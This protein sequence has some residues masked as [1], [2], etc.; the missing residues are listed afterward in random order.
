MKENNNEGAI[1]YSNERNN[2]RQFNNMKKENNNNEIINKNRNYNNILNNNNYEKISE[3]NRQLNHKSLKNINNIPQNLFFDNKNV[4][5]NLYL[6]SNEINLKNK[7]FNIEN[8]NKIDN[9]NRKYCQI[10][11]EDINKKI[12]NRLNNKQS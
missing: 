4:I 1:S 11:K 10:E 9:I 2:L 12:I 6:D 7:F 8:K 5:K 3:I